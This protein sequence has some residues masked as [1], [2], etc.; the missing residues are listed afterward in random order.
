MNP[1]ASLISP[2]VPVFTGHRS[3]FSSDG[4][5]VRVRVVTKPYVKQAPRVAKNKPR[6]ARNS[7]YGMGKN[8]VAVRNFISLADSPVTNS[9]ICNSTG[10]DYCAV[11]AITRR[12]VKEE[13]ITRTKVGREFFFEVRK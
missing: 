9:M 7:N 13:L 10:I 1:F 4:A 2:V 5:P 6:T 12:F 8:I 11:K 3:V